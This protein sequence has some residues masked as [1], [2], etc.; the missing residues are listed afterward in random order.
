M[1]QLDMS[2]NRIIK[3]KKYHFDYITQSKKKNYAT[4]VV[5]KHVDIYIRWTHRYLNVPKVR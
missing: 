2:N 1:L 4:F 5:H 3:L